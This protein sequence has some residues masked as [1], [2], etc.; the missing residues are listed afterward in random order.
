MQPRTHIFWA[1][2]LMATNIAACL[3][4]MLTRTRDSFSAFALTEALVPMRKPRAI[5]FAY[6]IM[7]RR[8]SASKAVSRRIGVC[9]IGGS[10]TVFTSLSVSPTPCNS[11]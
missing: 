6:S 8:T 3:I 1:I 2:V 4:D 11:S 7:L 10:A 5:V 9:L